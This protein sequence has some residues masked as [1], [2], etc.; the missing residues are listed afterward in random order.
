MASMTPSLLPRPWYLQSV[1]TGIS[2]ITGYGLGCLAAWAVRRCGVHP[3]WTAQTKR[4]GWWILAGCAVVAIP[5]FLYLGAD[6]QQTIRDLVGVPRAERALYISIL[7]LSLIVAWI[8][9]S[10][11]RGLRRGTNALTRF[12]DRFVPLPVARLTAL[13]IVIA[14]AVVVVNG[15]L[16]RGV[17][18]IA[19]STAEASDQS[20][21]EGVEQPQLPE[22]SGS[23]ESTQAWDSLGRE[24][25]TFVAG[26]PTAEQISAVTGAPARSPIRAY[27]GRESGADVDEIAANVVAELERTGAFDRAVLAVVTT[28]GRGWVNANVA[29][30]FEYVAGGDTAIASMQYSFLPSVLSFIADRETPKLAGQALFEAVYAAWSTR[31]EDQ[32]P[33]LVTFGESLGAFGGMSAFASAADMTARTDGGLWVGTPNFAQPWG[34][35]TDHRDPGSPERQPVYRDG[36]HVRFASQPE[37]VELGTTWGAPRTVFWQHASDPI[38]WWSF[39]LLLHQPDW[40]REPLGPDVDPGM[41]WLPFVTFWQVTMD[42]VFSTDVPSGFG[43]TYGAEAAYLWADILQP[44]GWSVEQSDRVFD[45]M[46]S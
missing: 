34:H 43:H 23:P 8:L 5:I 15:A 27:A 16:Y 9:L 11:G 26:G 12:I 33:K 44:A 13:V 19:E 18:S 46:T 22:R 4:I 41:R 21:A 1:A 2:V 45:A 39:D 29:N 25:R 36:E 35:I 40:L 3:A 7:I 30:S 37:D 6:N 28:T 42:M 31:P 10:I 17:L 38:V 20:T 32:R 24:G 14:L